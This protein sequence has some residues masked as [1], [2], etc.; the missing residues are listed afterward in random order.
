MT[1]PR[2]TETARSGG[3]LAG[4]LLLQ[5]QRGRPPASLQ[6][7]GHQQ[8]EQQQRKSVGS[9]LAQTGQQWRQQVGPA[10]AGAARGK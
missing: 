5:Q 2:W 4:G 7:R 3:R 8:R 6:R 9:T 1:R 10:A